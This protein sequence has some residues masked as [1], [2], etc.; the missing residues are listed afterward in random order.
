[1]H[2]KSFLQIA[3]CERAERRRRAL[4]PHVDANETDN[5]SRIGA[6]A[7]ELIAHD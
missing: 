2:C 5:R 3:V 4:V 1:M 7:R 6:E